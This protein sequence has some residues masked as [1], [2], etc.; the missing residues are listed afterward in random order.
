V[1]C[2]GSP[3]RRCLT[4]L[5]PPFRLIADN[6]R[7]GRVIPFLGAG[8][9]LGAPKPAGSERKDG[10]DALPTAGDLAR[11]LAHKTEFPQG[12]LNLATVAQ[13]YKVVGGREEL[14][15]EL[16]AIFDRDYPMSSLHT[17]L[18]SIPAPLLIVTTNYD[19]LIERAFEA[20]ARPY[21][22]VIHTTNAAIGDRLLWWRHGQPEPTE[23][24]PNKLELDLTEVSVLYKMHGAIDRR[25]PSRDQYVVTEDD[26]I[27]FLTRM[28]K[29]KAVPAMFAEPFQKRHFLFLGYGLSDWNLRVVLNRIDRDLHRRQDIRS[30][31]VDA[32][33]SALERRFWQDR[34]V[35]VYQMTIVEFISELAAV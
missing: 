22:L 11:R 31:S 21:D 3:A 29:N 25:E 23:V 18:A 24:S 14:E 20:A 27:D 9:S 28:T 26:Y 5:K 30:W 32:L 15:R 16:H 4:E 12:E 2:P 1:P 8:A 19:D 10:G 33:P 6:L 35:E 17:Y 7:E 13:Y 34:G